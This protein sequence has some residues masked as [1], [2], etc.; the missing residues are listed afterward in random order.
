M[1]SISYHTEFLWDASLSRG[2]PIC[3]CMER[4][5]VTIPK[6]T[7]SVLIY[8]MQQPCLGADFCV[9][10]LSSTWNCKM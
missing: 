1:G 6:R 10:E 7:Y 4:P 9:A 2:N 3:Q 5:K 8:K